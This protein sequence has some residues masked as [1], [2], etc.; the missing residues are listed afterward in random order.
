M[1]QILFAAGSK[2]A[3]GRSWKPFSLTLFRRHHI[4]LKDWIS[5]SF[6]QL[7]GAFIFL[8]IVAFFWY[9]CLTCWGC[10]SW[11]LAQEAPSGAPRSREKRSEWCLA[12]GARAGRGTELGFAW[13]PVHSGVAPSAAG[14]GLPIN[15]KKK[16]MY[17]LFN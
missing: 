2:V 15:E 10:V 7:R 1:V 11:C 9:S 8:F 3:G 6:Y 13:L 12:G 17:K 14:E 5:V 4:T 16:N